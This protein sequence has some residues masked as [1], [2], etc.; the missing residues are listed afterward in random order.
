MKRVELWDEGIISVKEAR[1]L[2]SVSYS[3]LSDETLM[4][5]IYYM[6]T[7]AGVEPALTG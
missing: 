3:G 6:V 5:V 4:G 1:K 7:S 2:L